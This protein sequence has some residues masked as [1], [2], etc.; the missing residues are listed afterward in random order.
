M[1]VIL[2]DVPDRGVLVIFLHSM[3]SA[4]HEALLA[5]AM[6]IVESS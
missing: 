3:Y 5:G 4:G 1:R 2:L 6:P